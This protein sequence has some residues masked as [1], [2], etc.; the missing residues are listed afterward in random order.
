MWRAWDVSWIRIWTCGP[1]PSPSW[2]AGCTSR[3]AGVGW[4]CASSVKP[5]LIHQNLEVGNSDIRRDM[6]AMLR[7]QRRTNRLLSGMAWVAMGFFLGLV[8]AQV[9]LRLHMLGLF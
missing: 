2:S 1:R 7:E 4:C 9:L 5:R 6:A 8:T 3:S